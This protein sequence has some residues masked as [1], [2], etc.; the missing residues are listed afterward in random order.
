L[1]VALLVVAYD[2]LSL[3]E[4]PLHLPLEPHAEEIDRF[5]RRLIEGR[6]KRANAGDAESDS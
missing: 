5:A 3:A 2:F 1:V 4:P 6:A